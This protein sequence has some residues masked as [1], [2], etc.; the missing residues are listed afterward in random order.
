MS[1]YK[2]GGIWWY[3][4]VLLGKRVR[5]SCHTA[6][7]TIARQAMERHRESLERALAGMPAGENN[8]RI[9]SIAE[10]IDEYLRL[11][12]VD[13]R[14]KSVSSANGRLKQVKSK[15]GSVLV[16]SVNENRVLEYMKLRLAE[17]ASG[18]TINM[19]IGELSRAIGRQ[20]SQIWPKVRKLEERKDVGRALSTTEE[21]ALLNGLR[22]SESPILG[23]F[24]QIALLTGMRSGEIQQLTWGQIDLSK[25]I[26]RVG[27]AKTHAG[28][29]RLIPVS[30]DLLPVLLS[31][32]EWFVLR[33][34]EPLPDWYL[35][36]FGSSASG[37]PTRHIQH[38]KTAWNTLR[39]RTGV[40]C[41]FH[42]L[43]HTAATK[44]AEA[45]T[46]EST[47]LALF[48]HVSRAMLERYSHV[49][50]E[51]KREAVGALRLA[52]LS[53]VP[54]ISHTE[55]FEKIIQ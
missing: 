14:A 36:P 39:R 34:G 4:F 32:R 49:R 21:V 33:F 26:L 45:G 1:L 37:D 24:V 15:L 47:M 30:D 16:P 35:F 6:K 13:H 46:A 8:S 20:W 29:G 19:E 55:K 31:H 38:V 53:V 43:R 25:R 17:G 9:A 22:A 11:Y 27:K 41:R 12:P 48:G 3:E 42:D 54:T 10:V 2:R 5:E 52:T 44:M 18:R 40:N 23:P 28:S 51:A 50:M 7:K